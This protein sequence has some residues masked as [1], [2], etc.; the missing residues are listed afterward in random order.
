MVR[1]RN[2]RSHNFERFSVHDILLQPPAENPYDTFAA[3]ENL[4]NIAS[5]F[6]SPRKNSAIKSQHSCFILCNTFLAKTKRRRTLPLSESSFVTN[7]LSCYSLTTNKI[8][9]S[10][11]QPARV[12]KAS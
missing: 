12:S 7:F 11:Q 1:L 2:R 4:T 9:S 6:S 10:T 5:N 8:V 3:R